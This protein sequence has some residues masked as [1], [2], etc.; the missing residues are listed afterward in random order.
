MPSFSSFLLSSLLVL[1]S[2]PSF[3]QSPDCASFQA[4]RIIVIG[5]STAAGTG[6]SHPDSS[7]VGRYRQHLQSINPDNEV[8]NLARGGYNTYRLMPDAFQTP[9]G[10]PS[11]DSSRNIS[12]ALRR[13]ASG[14]IV[15]LPSNDTGA[16]FLPSEQ[17]ANF[18]LIAAEAQNAGVPIWI[19]T[20]QPRN[21]NATL[22]A[23]QLE[24]R[25]SILVEYG[26]QAIDFWTPIANADAKIDSL[27]DS[28]DGVHV[29]D[30]GHA[31]LVQQVIE[32]DLPNQ[33]YTPS[34]EDDYLVINSWFENV[35]PCGGEEAKLY[36]AW[37]NL[38]G[39][40]DGS[41][42]LNIKG[43]GPD[44][45]RNYRFQPDAIP[46]CQTDTQMVNWGATLP[47]T[48]TI[49]SAI[50]AT[51]SGIPEPPSYDF[52]TSF[53]G[54]PS[55]MLTTETVCQ[56][57]SSRISAQLEFADRIFWFADP[58][59]QLPISQS[60]E[61]VSPPLDSSTLFYA[62]IVSGLPYFSAVTNSTD[63]PEVQ[64]NGYMLDVVAKE[65]L[66][67][68]SLAVKI[69]SLGQQSIRLY[70]KAGS[71]LGF[72]QDRDA[73]SLWEEM[74]IEV[75]DSNQ[76][77]LLQPSVPLFVKAGDTLALYLHLNGPASDLSYR[78]L[79]EASQYDGEAI[80]LLYGSGINHTFGQSYFPREWNGQLYYHYGDRPLGD[81]ATGLLPVE[82]QVSIPAPNLGPDKLINQDDTLRLSTTE[83]YESY[84]WSDG[85][86]ESEL[87]LIGS[88]YQ[89]GFYTFAVTITDFSGC[90]GTDTIEVEVTINT[91][92]NPLPSQTQLR[93]YPNPGQG[94]LWVELPNLPA[95]REGQLLL[96]DTNGRILLRSDNP[97]HSPYRMDAHALP[98]GLY[99]L[100]WTDETE[101]I[102]LPWIK[103]E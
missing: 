78:R 76:L 97:D 101:R 26:L 39:T 25:D 82:A 33:L 52:Q 63:V 96:R 17:L 44:R 70:Q 60:L 21:Y 71:H 35:S 103:I 72:E 47:G 102:R 1:L 68:D 12:E 13:Q 24:V 50:K 61:W 11:I 86:E 32:E 64:W 80:Q 85:S 16:G 37:I 54:L 31:L 9:M 66:V 90:Q 84:L 10:R 51:R 91:S 49:Q 3:A 100:E 14:I 5:S 29:N 45:E 75:V 46:L 23:R 20:T 57:D 95:R 6:S 41:I 77:D 88:D 99:W 36:V 89:P 53:S 19:T 43:Q 58:D 79:P 62:N 18:R 2:L 93:A 42:E 67:I 98:P 92:L 30:K 34:P 27:Y 56:G 69:H 28:G 87:V 22:T 8:I 48:Y 74:T 83:R 40:E 4:Q 55:A 59:G 38:G 65:D 7:W 81:C 15:N 94:E 73:W